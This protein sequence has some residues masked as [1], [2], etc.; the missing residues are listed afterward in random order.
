MRPSG[1]L[2]DLANNP[3][4]RQREASRSK[5]EDKISMTVDIQAASYAANRRGPAIGP[6]DIKSLRHFFSILL[7]LR[8]RAALAPHLSATIKNPKTEQKDRYQL[9]NR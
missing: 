5:T 7:R 3:T 1:T 4:R 8:S 9:T 6:A 2:Q